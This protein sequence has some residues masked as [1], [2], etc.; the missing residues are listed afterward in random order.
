MSGVCIYV[1]VGALNCKEK[2]RV[3]E[4]E[5]EEERNKGEEEGREGDGEERREQGMG[6]RR[7]A[8]AGGPG[9][10]HR[11]TQGGLQRHL[12]AVQPGNNDEHFPIQVI[13][14]KKLLPLWPQPQRERT[15]VTH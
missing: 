7:S 2:R 10:A 6:G 4:R 3:R 11:R 12:K 5:R 9:V 8:M 14:V 15:P 13:L 1:S